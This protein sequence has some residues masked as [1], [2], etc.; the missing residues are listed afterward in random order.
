MTSINWTNIT[1]FGDLPAQANVATDGMF[2]MGMYFMI[3][4]IIFLMVIFFGFEV[5]LLLSSFVALIIGL[6]LVYS[7]LLAWNYLLI[8]AGVILAT[9]LYIIWSSQ[10]IK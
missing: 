5:A 8:P 9:F 4:V 1:D 10:K 7:G 3:Y 2:W 6:M